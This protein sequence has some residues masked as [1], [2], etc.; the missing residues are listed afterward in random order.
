MLAQPVQ[1]LAVVGGPF[2]TDAGGGFPLNGGRGQGTAC[3]LLGQDQLA[4]GI[5]E[6]KGSLARGY[7]ADVLVVRGN[8]R[9]DPAA[10]L[11]VDR[12]Y[13]AGVRVR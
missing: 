5:G 4:G 13:R 1:G 6:R 10:L 12:V 2:L 7:A 8:P 3:G 9:L 11:D